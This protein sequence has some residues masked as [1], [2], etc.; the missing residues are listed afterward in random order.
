MLVKNS[1]R[2]SL[3]VNN[4]H[5]KSLEKLISLLFFPDV[6]LSVKAEYID[7]F[8][9]LGASV[10]SNKPQQKAQQ[11]DRF[12]QASHILKARD[13]GAVVCDIKFSEITSLDAFWRDY[14]NGSLLEAL[15][16]VFLTGKCT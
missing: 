3:S 14:V 4:D 16:G 10:H 1:S 12:N 8:E 11:L 2:I 7:H 9:V 15:K 6:R 13:L 5:E